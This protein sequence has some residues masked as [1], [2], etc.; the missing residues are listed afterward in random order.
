M[1]GTLETGKPNENVMNDPK[2]GKHKFIGL[3]KT[4]IKFPLIWF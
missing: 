4:A 3:G 1:Y 2:S